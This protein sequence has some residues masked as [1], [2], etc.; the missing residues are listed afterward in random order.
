MLGLKQPKH[1]IILS[2]FDWLILKM[3][4]L[5]SLEKSISIYQSKPK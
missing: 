3:K 5:G 1:H 4:T 2:F